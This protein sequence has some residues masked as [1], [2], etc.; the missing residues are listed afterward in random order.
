MDLSAGIGVS[1]F[2]LDRPGLGLDGLDHGHL[3]LG[4][5]GLGTSAGGPGVSSTSIGVWASA[6]IDIGL[7][8]G[9]PSSSTEDL[10][11]SRDPSSSAE[12]LGTAFVDSGP[13]TGDPG[14]GIGIL[15][16]AFVAWVPE[17]WAWVSGPSGQS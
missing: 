4:L 8:T 9:D 13:S 6:S 7:G 12:N 1:G 16:L 11:P 10:G 14:T 2:G 5:D 3:S 17:H 15:C